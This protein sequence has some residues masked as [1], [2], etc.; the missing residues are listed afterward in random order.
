[1]NRAPDVIDDA[2]ADAMRDAMET[3]A[4]RL[5]RELVGAARAGYE[6]LYV[7]DRGIDLA[8]YDPEDT[9]FSIATRRAYVPTNDRGVGKAMRG[10]TETSVQCYELAGLDAA[11]A[12][13]I[14]GE[15]D[16]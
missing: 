8:D 2:L 5:A 15:V 1:M 10:S 13:R 16:R 6:F 11:E 4:D 12:R 7:F 3:R 14:L 9:T